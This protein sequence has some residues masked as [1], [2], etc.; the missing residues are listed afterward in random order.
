MSV[1][2]EMQTEPAATPVLPGGVTAV[3]TALVTNELLRAIQ[4][5]AQMASGAKD[6][7]EV[8]ECGQAALTFAQAVITLDPTRLAGGDTPEGRAAATP[9]RPPMSDGDRDG[10]IGS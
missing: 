6:A 3:D 9:Q 5:S 1:D 4:W 2:P 7:R 10:I 8:R